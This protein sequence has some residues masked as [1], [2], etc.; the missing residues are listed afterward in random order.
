MTTDL[1]D[2]G[3][4]YETGLSS[5]AA[6]CAQTPDAVNLTSGVGRLF[7]PCSGAAE[8]H[9]GHLNGSRGG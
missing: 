6:L 7:A 4:L 1:D 3:M 5:K 8:C 9:F 2:R